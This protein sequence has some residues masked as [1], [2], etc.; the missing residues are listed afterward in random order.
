MQ[1]FFVTLVVLE[2][3]CQ[4]QV[5]DEFKFPSTPIGWFAYSEEICPEGTSVGKFLPTINLH[6]HPS[7][8]QSNYCLLHQPVNLHIH[9]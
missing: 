1:L 7:R 6:I 2:N 5:L 3:F 8:Y 9:P 4:A